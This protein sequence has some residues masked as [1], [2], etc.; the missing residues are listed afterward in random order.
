[1]SSYDRPPTAWRS[2]SPSISC[3]VGTGGGP[4]TGDAT[5]GIV[6]CSSLAGPISAADASV[7]FASNAT[8]SDA[9]SARLYTGRIGETGTTGPAAL[10]APAGCP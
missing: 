5:K 8:C 7:T 10:A 6:T 4:E 9:A 2:S 3:Y 1:M